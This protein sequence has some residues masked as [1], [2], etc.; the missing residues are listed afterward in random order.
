MQTHGHEQ[1][2]AERHASQVWSRDQAL[3]GPFHRIA[4]S[5]HR[6]SRAHGDEHPLGE[7]NAVERLRSARNLRVPVVPSAEEILAALSDRDECAVAKHH[8]V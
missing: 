7:G 8:A 4:R 2:I 1:P 6:A 5:Q 3:S